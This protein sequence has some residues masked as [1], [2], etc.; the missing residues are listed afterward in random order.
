MKSLLLLAAFS[1]LTS[2][3]G[4]VEPEPPRS[5]G[6]V[7]KLIH[8][9]DHLREFRESIVGMVGDLRPMKPGMPSWFWDEMEREVSMDGY[10]QWLV[11]IFE[12]GLSQEEVIQLN[13]FFGDSK[14]KVLMDKLLESLRGKKDDDFVRGVQEFQRTN[15]RELAEEI[16]RFMQTPVSLKYG[17]VLREIGAGRREITLKLFSEAD[18]RI[19]VR[20]K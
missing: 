15:D 20:H 5:H 3:L 17:A 18:Q 12:K 6:E 10:A 1:L 19:R 2:S 4:A 16:I 13:A 9:T 14:K 11:G 8:F 7:L